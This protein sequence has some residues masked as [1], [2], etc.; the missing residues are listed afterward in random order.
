MSEQDKQSA[1]PPWI[2]AHLREYAENPAK[3]HNWDATFAGGRPNTPT[4]LLTTTGRKSGK[5][6]TLP[7]I[8]GVDGDRHLIVGSKG[9]APEHPLWYLNLQAD[10][11]AEIQVAEKHYKV[12]AKTIGDEEHARLWQKMVGIYSPFADYQKRTERRIPIIALEPVR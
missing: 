9:G 7:L 11:N 8:Y 4:L 10:P 12:V 5:R 3:A 1:L 2:V 6:M